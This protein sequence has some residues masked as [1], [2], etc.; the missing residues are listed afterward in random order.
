MH[1]F[2]LQRIDRPHNQRNPYLRD[3]STL[4]F[5]KGLYSHP[6]PTKITHCPL[7][8]LTVQ[9]P[10]ERVGLLS[11]RVTRSLTTPVGE[12]TGTTSKV[13]QQLGPALGR[14]ATQH[15][16]SPE[17]RHVVTA[18]TPEK[19]THNPE[20]PLFSQG[21]HFIYCSVYLK[22]PPPSSFLFQ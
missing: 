21:I 10:L 7:A 14:L 18:A 5:Q 19:T 2:K 9:V 12:G 11:P 17:K 13:G 3:L 15:L 4:K 6:L 22:I 8:K 16:P 20:T 1:I